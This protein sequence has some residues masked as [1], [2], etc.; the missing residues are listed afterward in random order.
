MDVVGR[1]LMVHDCLSDNET[2][3]LSTLPSGAYTL[4]I[5]THNQTHIRKVVKK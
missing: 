1:K 3:D 4:R 2:I 5:V